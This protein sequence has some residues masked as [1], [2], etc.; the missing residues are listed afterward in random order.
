ML[1]GREAAD[2][3][4]LQAAVREVLDWQAKRDALI[5]TRYNQGATVQ[6]I[7]NESDLSRVEIRRALRQRGVNRAR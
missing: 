6:D 2:S 5:H 4:K 7:S 3:K 1:T